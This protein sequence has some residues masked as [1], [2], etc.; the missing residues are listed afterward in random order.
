MMPNDKLTVRRAA[1]CCLLELPAEE[2]MRTTSADV[3]V[4][5]FQCFQT[6]YI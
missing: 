4:Q 5:C 1:L 3:S 6:R 2:A